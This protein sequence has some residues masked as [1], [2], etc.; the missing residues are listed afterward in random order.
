MF[1]VFLGV[2]A[3]VALVYVFVRIVMAQRRREEEVIRTIVQRGRRTNKII[4]RWAEVR[5]RH[6]LRVDP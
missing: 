6:H 1:F 5:R 3:Y 4:T 2:V